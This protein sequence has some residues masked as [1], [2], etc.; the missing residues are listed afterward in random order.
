MHIKLIQKWK[1]TFGTYPFKLLPFFPFCPTAKE[2]SALP[3]EHLR[4]IPGQEIL[5]SDKFHLLCRVHRTE[6]ESH[7]LTRVGNEFSRQ[8]QVGS[9]RAIAGTQGGGKQGGSQT[10]HWLR[11][12]WS[13]RSFLQCNVNIVLLQSRTSCRRSLC[14]KQRLA[15][16]YTTGSC[17]EIKSHPQ[18]CINFSFLLCTRKIDEIK[19]RLVWGWPWCKGQWQC[20]FPNEQKVC[21]LIEWY[22]RMWKTLQEIRP[23]LHG[24]HS[25]GRLSQREMTLLCSPLCLLFCAHTQGTT[26]ISRCPKRPTHPFW[27]VKNNLHGKWETNLKSI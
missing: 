20:K 9:S 7:S 16:Y 13:N 17:W 21:L 10:E 14:G 22:C 8:R 24:R 23:R 4:F 27:T 6:A 3:L 15:I 25:Y 1:Q 2:Q 18:I 26:H 5:L 11:A 12:I 19:W